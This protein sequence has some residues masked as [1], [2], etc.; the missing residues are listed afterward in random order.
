M[1]KD[2][3]KALM[4]AKGPVSSGY[5]PSRHITKAEGEKVKSRHPALSIPGVHIREE[6]HGTPTFT[7]DQYAN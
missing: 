3:R 2:V 4:I 6:I 5:L 1:S 7:G